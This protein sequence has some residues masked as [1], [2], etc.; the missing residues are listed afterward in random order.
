MEKT[1]LFFLV[2][3][4]SVTASAQKLPNVQ[5]ESLRAPTNVKIDGKANEWGDFKTYNKNV[6]VFYALANDNDKLYLAIKATDKN[7]IYKIIN[8][9]ISF[10]VHA[11]GKKDDDGE[12]VITYPKFDNK[13]FPSINLDNKPIAKKGLPVSVTRMDSFSNAMSKNLNDRAK[14]IQVST[15]KDSTSMLSI[16][17]EFGIN[18]SQLI[19]NQLSYIYELAVPLKYLHISNSASTIAYNIKLNGMY[20]TLPKNV[21]ITAMVAND[22]ALN[23]LSP[24]DFWGEY[25]LAK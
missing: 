16:Y 19:D 1:V 7:I 21:V 13:N 10:A 5:Q 2:T 18:A 24:T 22:T 9:G 12:I 11:S 3:V 25:S 20:A 14:M 4:A 15:Q 17:N 8:G 6:D 23:A